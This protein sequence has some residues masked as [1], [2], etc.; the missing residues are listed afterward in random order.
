MGRLWLFGGKGGVGK[1]T[2]SAATALWL[3]RAGFRT[4]VVS[5]DPA[6]ST[7]DS[8][9]YP[10]GPEPTPVADE[11]N[12]WGMELDPERT[13]EQVLPKFSEAMSGSMGN[14]LTGMFTGIDTDSIQ[15]EMSQV[16][17]SQLM[18][19]GLDEALA[20]DQLLRYV[21]D[22]R[23]DVIIFD[24]APTGHTLRF[25]SL[26]EV[27]DSWMDRILRYYR[28]TG[29]LR[30]ML[31]GG[32][33]QDAM[34]E[35]LEKFQRRVSHVRRVLTDPELANFT[36]VC[37]PEQMAVAETT[38]AAEALDEYGITVNGIIV[39]RVTPDFDHPFI[40]S[41]RET[42]QSYLEDLRQL[43]GGLPVAEVPLS[44]SDVHGLDS[45]H[46]LALGL[47]GDEPILPEDMKPISVSS[48]IPINLRRGLNIR[49]DEGE[50][51]V[52]MYLPAANK[53]DLNLRSE[54]NDLYIGV[55]GREARIDVGHRV[56]VKDAEARFEDDI[57]R[58]TVK[59]E[60]LD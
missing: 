22:P 31:F 39:N 35:E 58:L 49:K 53:E 57:L 46:S 20:F 23:F 45:L 43:F 9:R 27:L 6:H 33:K 32:K 4:L 7:S 29:G 30:M 59:G 48:G 55:N 42:E 50:L 41:R 16:E 52:E 34:R 51:V 14:S 5:S 3:A 10:L 38:R 56:K 12:L 40:Q 2:S 25:L 28:M 21:E 60:S 26:P 54:G 15:D 24:T 8:L 44:E 37:I 11:E 13:I 1:T 18:I 36:L 47:H 19:P 17:A